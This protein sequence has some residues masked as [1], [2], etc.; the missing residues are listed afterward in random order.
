M[1][2]YDYPLFRPPAEANNVI[3]QVTYGC[4]YNNCSFCSMYKTKNYEVRD[5]DAVK[6]DIDALARLNP[7]ATKVFL[8]DGDALALDALHLL[9]ILQY[10]QE[11]FVKLRR[12]SLYAS[13][14]NLLNKSKEEL[15]LLVKN[16]LT[17]IYYGI[18]T[19]SDVVLKK[20]TKGVSQK[21]IIDSLNLASS[22]GFKIS[23]TVIL[24]IGGEKYSKT[25]IE[26]TAK[27]IKQTTPNYLSTLQLG[28]EDD[29]QENFYKHFKDFSPLSDVAV[30]KEQKYFLELLHPTNKIIFRSNH[31]S[32]AL[33]LAGTLPKDSD[34]LVQELALALEV[35]EG[36]FIPHGFRSLL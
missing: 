15:E 33:H 2:E 27:V 13:T 11:K 28:L 20:I 21:E 34:R 23:A 3:L 22:A 1:L 7:L 8:A 29:A 4:S 12:I 30:L 31:A 36:A 9:K 10:L 35:G 24:G 32:N 16:K 25:H 14:Q 6:Q 5:I 18:E 17:L 19:G 26:E